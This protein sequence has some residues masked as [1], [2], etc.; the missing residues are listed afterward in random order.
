MMRLWI[1]GCSTMRGNVVG[2]GDL[3]ECHEDEA[4]SVRPMVC[5]GLRKSLNL[6]VL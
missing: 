6:G 3:N 2:A 1:A 4:W 5:L